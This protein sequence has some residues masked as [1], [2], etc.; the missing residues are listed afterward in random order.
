MHLENAK[1]VLSGIWIMAIG[2]TAMAAGITQVSHWLVIGGVAI[3]PP[4]VARML[5]QQ[6]P[7]TL[8]ESIQEARR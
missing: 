5:W 1:T 4:I 6:P 7:Q 8:S 3:A 2:V